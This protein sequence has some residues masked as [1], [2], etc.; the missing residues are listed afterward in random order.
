MED[1]HESFDKRENL[2]AIMEIGRHENQTENQDDD[3]VSHTNMT[4]TMEENLLYN[5]Y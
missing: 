4:N 3:M 1:D 2:E 5:Q